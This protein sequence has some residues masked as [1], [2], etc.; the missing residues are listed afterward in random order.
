MDGHYPTF[1]NTG[2]AGL[3]AR[4]ADARYLDSPGARQM[5]VWYNFF[6]KTRHWELE[7][8]FD[9]EGGRA[10]ALEVPRDEETPEGIEYIVYVEK[11]GPVEIVLQRHGYD[12]AWINPL[13]G[14]RRKQKGFRGNRLRIQP[15]DTAHDW[16]LHVSR[17]D[18]KESMLRSYRFETHAI[19]LQEV[20]QSEQRV[21][22]TIVEP[23]PGTLKA[24]QPVRFA[25]KIT[26]ESRATQ[27]MRWLWTVEVSAE[28]QG[29]RVVGTGAEGEMTIPPGLARNYP[30]VLNLRLAAMNASGKVY[31]LDR[32]YRLEP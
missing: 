10:L 32:I 30:A 1:A 11:P 19:L 29:Y 17:E 6:Q 5:T 13:T 28:G 2:A 8:Y 23:A 16:V 15:P 26:R 25:A 31:F 14:E 20:E 22:Y 4:P 18:K 27:N 24:G 9:V 3:S 21:P 12:V 7:P